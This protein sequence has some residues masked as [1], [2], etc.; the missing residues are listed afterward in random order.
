MHPSTG[1]GSR[2]AAAPNSNSCVVV[3]DDDERFRESLGRLLRAAGF[4]P[5]LFPS[6]NDF[7]GSAPPDSPTCLILDVRLPERSGLDFQRDLAAAGV[8]RPIVFVTGHG[9]IPMS[10]QA[11]K[12]GAIEFLTKPF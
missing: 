11:M 3:I 12:A 8:T 5:L 7:V 9:D 1:L 10:V 2:A 4:N 6:I